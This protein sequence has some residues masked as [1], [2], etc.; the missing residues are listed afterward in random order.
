MFHGLVDG[1]LVVLVHLVK[2]IDTTHTL[3]EGGGVGERG[4][5]GE[6]EVGR[7]GGGERGRWGVDRY[8]VYSSLKTP[9]PSPE[10]PLHLHPRHL[11]FH[12]GR[13][14]YT[15]HRCIKYSGIHEAYVSPALN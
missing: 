12:Y 1:R 11:N 15:L 3:R 13:S 6:G 5:W 4:R 14:S 7:G 10:L 8:N 9:I 2:L